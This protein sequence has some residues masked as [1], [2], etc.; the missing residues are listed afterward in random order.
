MKIVTVCLVLMLASCTKSA[1]TNKMS[2][3]ISPLAEKGKSLVGAKGCV[4]CHT[5]EGSRLVG[6]SFK[7][8]FGKEEKLSDGTNVKVDENYIRESIESPQA[9]IVEGYPPSMPTYKGLVTDEEIVAIMEYI[10]SLK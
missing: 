3:E 2:E 1:T 7:G 9:K 10:K 8:I 6:P 4:A 5:A